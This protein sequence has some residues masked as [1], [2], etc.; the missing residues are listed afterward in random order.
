MP[1]APRVT[2]YAY[3]IA[4]RLRQ[5]R[6]P[7]A[8]AA[9]ASRVP[10]IDATQSVTDIS[11]DA[12]GRVASLT[13]PAPGARQG[14]QHRAYAYLAGSTRVS[15]GTR[16]PTGLMAN[17]SYDPATLVPLVIM[18]SAG[19]RTTNKWNPG[20]DSLLSTTDAADATTA[21]GYENG[22]L[23]SRQGPTVGGPGAAS[24]SLTAGYDETFA[25]GSK[26]PKPMTGLQ[27]TYWA[28][29]GFSGAPA[30]VETGPTVDGKLPP[31]LSVTWPKG[32]AG[33]G[34]G[35]WSARLTG[36]WH[37]EV[38]GTYTVTAA[39]R[40]NT[41]LWIDNL[42]C[43]RGTCSYGLK[44]G[45]YPI[46]VDVTQPNAG[47][48]GG[49]TVTAARAGQPPRAIAMTALRPAY[50]LQTST[51]VTD[52]SSLG[53]AVRPTTV[54]TYANAALGQLTSQATDDQA[55]SAATY[56]AV[57]VAAGALGRQT[58]IVAPSGETRAL[59]YWGATELAAAPGGCG[60][61]AVQGGLQ[62]SFTDAA[63]GGSTGAV[64]YTSWYDAA[65]RMRA[66]GDGHHR[67]CVTY[68]G[69][70]RMVS[71]SVTGPAEPITS[72]VDYTY[73]GNP[74]Q[75]RT[76]STVGTTATEVTARIDL[77]GR[78]VAVVDSWGTRTVTEYDGASGLISSEV[79]VTA[80]QDGS[81]PVTTT[82]GYTYTADGA[83]H[84][85]TV[86]G[87]TLATVDYRTD[88][89]VSSIR[90]AN[91]TSVSY[92]YDGNERI[93]TATGTASNGA[94]HVETRA[95]SAAG[96]VLTD[97]FADPGGSSV[98]YYRYDPA[99][100]LSGATLD[101]PLAVAH[102]SWA[103][104]YDADSNRTSQTVDGK[105]YT[106]S[107]T[108]HGSQLLSTTDPTIGAVSYDAATGT[109]ITGLGSQRM[110]Y[111]SANNLVSASDATTAVTLQRDAGGS[112]IAKTTQ[113]TKPASTTTV[114]Y[115]QAGLV[116]DTRNRLLSRVISLPGG[117]VL[118]VSAAAPTPTRVSEPDPAVKATK[119]RAVVAAAPA[120]SSAAAT[121]PAATTPAASPPAA[122]TVAPVIPVAP[123]TPPRRSGEPTAAPA[124]TP[125]S[126]A[127]GKPGPRTPPSPASSS[128][129]SSTRPS[130]TRTPAAPSPAPSA[131][132][133]APKLEWS[134]QS[135]NGSTWWAAD[136]V[137]A[138]AGVAQ[139]YDPFGQS[140]TRAASGAVSTRGAPHLGW[141]AGNGLET[142][143][144][145]VDLVTMGARAYVPALGRFLQKDPELGGGPNVYDYANQ[146]PINNQDPSG[147]SVGGVV[148]SL[149]YLALTTVGAL[150]TGGG[151]LLVQVGAAIVVG[152][153]SGFVCS[154]IQQ[155]IDTGDIDLGTAGE[156][157]AVDAISNGVATFISIKVTEKAITTA[158]KR[159]AAAAEEQGLP[160]L[161]AQ[162]AA[163]APANQ[164]G[165]A[166]EPAAA[167]AGGADAAAMQP[168]IPGNFQAI[169]QLI[170]QGGPSRAVAPN[171]IT[172]HRMGVKGQI[173]LAQS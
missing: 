67:S 82:T 145:D 129:A 3:D 158:L 79:T 42:A 103:Y 127:T 49:V 8:A 147:H 13:G 150:V 141:Q 59:S 134:Y 75:V 100:R 99:G 139:L 128:A 93:T 138:P 4:G 102:R 171:V 163:E 154:I 157:A 2:D 61:P 137:G 91:D 115:S 11:Y 50:G 126:S 98:F 72:A 117:V 29:A 25:G 87:R 116:L 151:S 62:K 161:A 26:N 55:P 113:T 39:P 153:I 131:K 24:P 37:V 124:A 140:L 155:E 19:R 32:P 149:L 53:N 51:T 60:D 112:V 165:I 27:A 43:V 52:A 83:I 130:P 172:F 68:D 90:Y 36:I 77:L 101:T 125:T 164:G 9:V 41:S 35:A 81:A 97:R 20:D 46:R 21:Y 5:V 142:L 108:P 109:M 122:A 170:L 146:D 58:G 65:G 74:L 123:A 133:A 71:T 114:R 6:S 88:G 12:Q 132:A 18:D 14:R 17:V 89:R 144:L 34:G 160:E 45:D 64:T 15:D 22:K 86:D 156:A 40:S 57:D 31:A 135:L 28:N 95:L 7:L 48:A 66:Q 30:V 107:Y 111:D 110:A 70:G 136:D 167:A 159:N 44:A 94:T 120:T 85:Q 96:R 76:T 78:T 23:V 63:T 47:G 169:E 162:R 80:P 104:T 92:S 16:T 168:P 119:A 56:E 118:T 121:T 106:Y 173:V 143:D 38:D 152:A 73:L 1:T 166:A 105:Q 69:A 54:N 10:G 148:E 33:L 84:T